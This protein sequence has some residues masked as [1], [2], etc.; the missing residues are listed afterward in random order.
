MTIEKALMIFA[1]S[2]V[3]ISALLSVFVDQAW[4]WLT[5]F[6]GF[7]MIQSSFTG[8]CP[9]V[10]VMKKLGLKSEAETAVQH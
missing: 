2:V 4:S 7:N 8:F 10:I 9:A 3:V 6:A 5:V 1:G